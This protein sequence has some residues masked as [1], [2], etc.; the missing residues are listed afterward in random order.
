METIHVNMNEQQVRALAK[1]EVVEARD[2]FDYT[3]RLL[4]DGRQ[5]V[6]LDTP[7]LNLILDG[8]P[9]QLVMRDGAN[10]EIYFVGSE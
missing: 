4:I 3:K 10:L 9:E 1:G 6:G 5:V 2:H 8:Y 7:T